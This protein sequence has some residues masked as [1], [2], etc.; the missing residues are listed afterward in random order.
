[1]KTSTLIVI[2][3]ISSLLALAL[4]LIPLVSLCLAHNNIAD[5]DLVII[6]YKVIN[7]RFISLDCIIAWSLSAKF[8]SE[9]YKYTLPLVLSSYILD[10]V[11]D[12]E[13]KSWTAWDLHEKSRNL[14][15][16]FFVIMIVQLN[17][18]STTS[19]NK[20]TC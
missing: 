7:R 16:I 1:M 3:V 19:L 18:T 4:F 5:S 15:H 9:I 6:P 17:K 11:N 13:S 10:F 8:T 12:I 14:I 20:T 2:V